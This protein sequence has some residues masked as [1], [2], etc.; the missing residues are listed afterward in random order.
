MDHSQSDFETAERLSRRRARALPA[1]AAIFITQQASFLIG[2]PPV[3]ASRVVELMRLWTWVLLSLV[4]VA[5]LWSNGFWF[6]SKAV[7]ALLND[8]ATRAHR[9]DAMSLGFT[10]AMLAAIT[11]YI[12][13]FVDTV[14]TRLALH[15]VVTGGVGAAVLRFGVLE[16][17]AHR[18]G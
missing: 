8:E 3:E 11:L 10:L 7:R 1:L 17:R 12:V 2:A 4:L 15:F 14:P 18:V 13:S 5:A 6:R 16:R 9:A